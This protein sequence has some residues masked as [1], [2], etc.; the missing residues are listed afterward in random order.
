MPIPQHIRDLARAV[1]DGSEDVGCLMALADEIKGFVDEPDGFKS[2]AT[3]EHE[4]EAVRKAAW[5]VVRHSSGMAWPF[6]GDLTRTLGEKRP[7]KFIVSVDD[8]ER[9]TPKDVVGTL[10][11]LAIA[12]KR[13]GGVAINSYEGR[14]VTITTQVSMSF[15]ELPRDFPVGVLLSEMFYGSDFGFPAYVQP[16]R[17]GDLEFGQPGVAENLDRSV[18]RAAARQASAIRGVALPPVDA[19]DVAIDRFAGR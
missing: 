13:M 18:S 17:P 2:R 10:N 12:A 11:A 7:P 14:R 15:D 6:G 4:R 3:L 5:D 9:M 16:Y 8:R 19:T 1:A